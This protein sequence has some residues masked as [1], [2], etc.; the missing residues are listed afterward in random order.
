[1]VAQAS[2]LWGHR[3]SCLVSRN[4][5]A[6]ATPARPTAK[7]AVLHNPV[8]QHGVLSGEQILHEFVAGFVRVA[9]RAREVMVDPHARGTTEII[10]DR[11][12]FIG[13]FALAKQPL[14]IS[15]SRTDGK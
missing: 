11:Q 3:A 9:R 6:G 13:R 14:R 5:S 12:N 10:R 8:A 15:A 7:M 1:M 2:R 4:Q